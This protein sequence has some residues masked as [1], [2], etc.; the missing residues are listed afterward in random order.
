MTSLT[1]YCI[2]RYKGE[3]TREDEIFEALRRAVPKPHER[4]KH[5]NEWISEEMWRLIDKR[6]SARRGTGVRVKIRR[7]GRA[8]RESLQVERKRRLETAGTDVESLLGGEPP[9]PK[10]AWRRLKGWY[11][12][13]VNR[14][15]PP[16]RATL[17][18]ITAKRVD[19]YIYVPPPGENIPVT[20]TPEDV[21]DSVTKEDEIAEAVKKLRRNWSGGPSGMRAE[22]LKEWFAAANR[23][24]LAEEKT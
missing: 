17:E 23:G 11:K 10:E 7:L 8:I 6:V 1:L 2:Y 9:N 5:K 16:T 18:R 19:L 20:I 14:A 15:P 21:D 3:P 12:T 4:D 24:K 22:H 13:A